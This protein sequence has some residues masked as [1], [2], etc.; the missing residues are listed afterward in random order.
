MLTQKKLKNQKIETDFDNNLNT[1]FY[2]NIQFTANFNTNDNNNF[3]LDSSIKIPKILEIKEKEKIPIL[4]L[5][6]RD[7]L[8]QINTLKINP[9]GLENGRRNKKDGFVYFGYETNE[10]EI[11]EQ[12][13]YLLSPNQDFFREFD[14]RFL[15]KYFQIRFEPFDYKYYIKDLGKGYGSFIKLNKKSVE[16]KNNTIFN[17]G[18]NYLL[19]K[20]GEFLNNDF[21]INNNN[22]NNNNSESTENL[23]T[24]LN[25]QIFESNDKKK[26]FN[27]SSNKSPIIIGRS[28]ETDIFL[29]DKLLSRKHCFCEFKNNKWYINDGKKENG[30]IYS[31][32]NGTWIYISE[33]MEIKN[34][35]IFKAN[36]FV[37]L[38]NLSEINQ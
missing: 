23:E 26:V 13:D 6:I 7:R 27:F 29:D 3:L 1:N 36:H 22:N 20:I 24:N 8:S 21:N 12:I 33:E 19:F 35:M 2:N 25:I 31:S 16:I 11:E 14:D 4:T 30:I 10:D 15:G 18:E 37:F 38:C 28:I 34:N 32:T 17:I 5:E 9:T